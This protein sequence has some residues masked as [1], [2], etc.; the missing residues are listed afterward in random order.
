MRDFWQLPWR[1]TR[2]P[3][4]FAEE[5]T[6]N[7]KV[8]LRVDVEAADGRVVMFVAS[9]SAWAVRQNLTLLAIHVCEFGPQAKNCKISWSLTK[10]DQQRL[11]KIEIML[12]VQWLSLAWGYL[13][14]LLPRY[15]SIKIDWC[16]YCRRTHG[17]SINQ[18]GGMRKL[19]NG[20]PKSEF[21]HPRLRGCSMRDMRW[22][23]T[24]SV[25]SLR[26]ISVARKGN[27]CIEF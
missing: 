26:L 24:F 10:F 22:R 1:D 14:G 12:C 4:G 17:V 19:W 23:H 15:H 25:R 16:G 20:L 9:I 11:V 2:A 5:Q 21:L 3:A 6:K 8:C 7:N 27:Y 13:T 18:R